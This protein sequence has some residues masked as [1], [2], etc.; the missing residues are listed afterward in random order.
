MDAAL[1]ILNRNFFVFLTIL[2]NI[3]EKNY[4]SLLNFIYQ[5]YSRLHVSLQYSCLSK[6]IK[7]V[8]KKHFNRKQKKCEFLLLYLNILYFDTMCIVYSTEKI[9]L[10]FF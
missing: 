7:V 3:T 8:I 9:N 5:Y 2:K 6:K 10:S 4:I 1:L